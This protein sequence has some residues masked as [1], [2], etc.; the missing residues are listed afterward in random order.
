MAKPFFVYL[1]ALHQTV[2]NVSVLKIKMA[3]VFLSL[4][5]FNVCCLGCHRICGWLQDPNR[6]NTD[7]SKATRSL[8]VPGDKYKGS[9][10]EAVAYG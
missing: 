6:N 5:L 10:A 1:E 7:N 8:H 4:N 3:A 9:A 2:M